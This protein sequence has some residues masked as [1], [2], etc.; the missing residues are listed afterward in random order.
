M[1][2][3]LKNFHYIWE[4]GLAGHYTYAP[5]GKKIKNNLENHLR[6]E[7]QFYDFEEVET[8]IIFKKEVWEHS[9]HWDK[10]QDPVIYTKSGKC[11]RIDK[12][13]EER[14]PK[15]DYSSLKTEQILSILSS[16]NEDE[17]ELE[18]KQD[19]LQVKDAIEYQSLMIRSISGRQEVGLRPET[20]TATYFHYSDLFQAM[21]KQVPIKVFQIGK[22]FR[23]EV[24]PKHGIIRG[25]EFT[26]AEFQVIL[27]N[28]LKTTDQLAEFDNPFS[29]SCDAYYRS[30]LMLTY[31]TFLKLGLNPNNVR[32]RRHTSDEMAFYALD[33]YDIEVN[34]KGLGW[35]EVAGIHDRG[36][37]DL[38]HHPNPLHILE[39][40]IG[41]D[42]LVYSILD[43]L[44][45]EKTVSD[46][47]SMLKLPYYLAPI[48]VS[49]LPL[50]KNKPQLTSKAREI[51]LTLKRNFITEYS[52]K[53]SI[54]KRYLSNA[55]RGIPYS[56]TIDYDTVDETNPNFDTVTVRDRDTEAQIRIKIN[57][58]IPYLFQQLFQY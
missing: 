9:G 31:Q 16:L 51:Y 11:H 57:D 2:S 56:L 33:A 41:I 20:A 19:P 4:T 14:N 58:L 40:A 3:F 42:R 8:P 48:Q 6:R 37:Y 26:Q 27:P 10:F 47:K 13:L 34:L 35:T 54:G 50:V 15:I 39:V 28:E 7:F 29:L 43:N 23:N 36:S 30:L 38:R 5:L 21:N 52:E 25:R 46:G 45:E 49:I 44:Y 24:S 22:S 17:K 32:I 55:Q 1:Q 12:L 18:F 53:Q